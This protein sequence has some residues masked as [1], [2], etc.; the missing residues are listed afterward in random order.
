MK[1]QSDV[2]FS[3]R[4]PMAI[5]GCFRHMTRSGWCLAMI[6][7]DVSKVEDGKCNQDGSLW[8]CMSSV[9]IDRGVAVACRRSSMGLVG[10][11]FGCGI[12]RFQIPNKNLIFPSTFSSHLSHRNHNRSVITKGTPLRGTAPLCQRRSVSEEHFILPE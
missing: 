5:P 6:Q 12:D 9:S 10:D 11:V 7:R 2:H 8:W 4:R 3:Q 1:L